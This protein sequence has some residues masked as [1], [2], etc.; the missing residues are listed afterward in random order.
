MDS[1]TATGIHD[2]R[3]K[4]AEISAFDVPTQHH[5]ENKAP[6]NHRVIALWWIFASL[7]FLILSPVVSV[8]LGLNLHARDF[9][10][11]D[12]KST[13]DG[14]TVTLSLRT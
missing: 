5:G 3:P 12:N 6:R 2:S 14:R 13:F 9:Q 7:S 11:L 10:Y 1:P 8:L 4:S